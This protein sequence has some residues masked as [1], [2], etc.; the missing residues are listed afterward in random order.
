MDRL[1]E[2][3]DLPRERTVRI[4]PIV[5]TLPA[6]PRLELVR[7]PLGVQR[8]GAIFAVDFQVRAGRNLQRPAQV[9]GADSTAL[10]NEVELCRV[11]HLE[12]LDAGAL[13]RDARDIAEEESDQVGRMRPV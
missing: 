11:L 4:A 9:A 6:T 5:L 8:R 10:H 7:D 2:V 12:L 3:R 1:D 13:R